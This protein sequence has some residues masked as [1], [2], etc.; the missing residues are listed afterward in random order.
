MP[1]L[2]V[3][4]W[5]VRVPVAKRFVAVEVGVRHS[6][7]ERR[8]VRMLVVQI[9]FVLVFMLQRQVFVVVL[10]LFAQVQPHRQLL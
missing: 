5:K 10:V 3:R 2:V 7:L 1:M 6:G 8:F 9:M 4:V